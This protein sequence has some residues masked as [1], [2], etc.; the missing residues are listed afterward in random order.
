MA[1]GGGKAMHRSSSSATTDEQNE[2]AADVGSRVLQSSQVD[3]PPAR[4]PKTKLPAFTWRDETDAFPTQRLYEIE[5]FIQSSSYHLQR[6]PVSTKITKYSDREPQD[7]RRTENSMFDDLMHIVH[8]LKES[9]LYTRELFAQSSRKVAR[10]ARSYSYGS[11]SS[12]KRRRSGQLDEEGKPGEDA[13]G[14]EGGDEKEEGNEDNRSEG[15]EGEEEEA[16]DEDFND[17]AVNYYESDDEGGGG[18][19]DEPAM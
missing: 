4:F 9:P 10:L 1:S 19:D 3:E 18:E 2:D 6:V 11:T 14:K 13:S 7:K 5:S 12:L 17:Y 8:P 15:A 16:V